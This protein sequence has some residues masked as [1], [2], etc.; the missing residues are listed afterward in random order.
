[1]NTSPRFPSS[2]MRS[3]LSVPNRCIPLR[4]ILPP[5]LSVALGVSLAIAPMMRARADDDAPN[6]I[7]TELQAA[8]SRAEFLGRQMY[9]HD[10]AAWLATDAM[11]ADQRM[12]ALKP[13]LGGWVT[14][15]T[16]HGIRTIFVSNDEVPV[17]LYEIEID[18]GERLS[19]AML[20][21]PEPL[22]AEH[23][24]QLSAREAVRTRDMLRCAQ[25]YNAVSMPSVDGLR[26]YAMPAFEREHVYPLGGYHLF[27]FEADGKT[28]AESRKFTNGCIEHDETSRELPDGSKAI[29]AMFTH[30]LDPQPTEVHVFVSIYAKLPLTIVTA[31]NK[32][33]WRVHKGKIEF[34]N[35]LP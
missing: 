27:R 8:V 13:R 19:E 14:E 9:L 15:P 18:E 26:V 17:R 35:A 11:F 33:M 7:P 20:E 1:M 3:M 23:R 24:A 5:A 29:G 30:L 6:A 10:R 2:T 34:L 12:E 22:T 21:S 28:V 31:D 25:Q 32:S 4:S 16:A